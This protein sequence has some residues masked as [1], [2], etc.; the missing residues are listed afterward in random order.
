MTAGIS[1]ICHLFQRHQTIVDSL[2]YAE[3]CL[4]RFNFNNNFLCAL[5]LITETIITFSNHT[6][7]FIFSPTSVTRSGT[8]FQVDVS[9][10]DGVVDP[11]DGCNSTKS[12]FPQVT[13]SSSMHVRRRA[14]CVLWLLL[15]EDMESISA[16]AMGT[17]DNRGIQDTVQLTLW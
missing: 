16:L 3:C 4:P 6:C 11:S 15:S 13:F 9:E 10:E 14:Q 8:P 5:D 12:P 7:Y 2:C 17:Y 1:V